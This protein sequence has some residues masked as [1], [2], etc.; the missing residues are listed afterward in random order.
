MGL[1]R[2]VVVD[3]NMYVICYIC[4]GGSLLLVLDIMLDRKNA[5]LGVFFKPQA[6]AHADREKGSKKPQL[7]KKGPFFQHLRVIAE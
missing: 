7:S 6:C 3:T 4:P 2:P 1:V 5:G